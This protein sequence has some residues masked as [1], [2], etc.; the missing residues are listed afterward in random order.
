MAHPA[1][2]FPGL[3]GGVL[4]GHPEYG[5]GAQNG[6]LECP[7]LTMSDYF[8]LATVASTLRP[9]ADDTNWNADTVDRGQAKAETR[10]CRTG[11]E[12]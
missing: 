1:E 10:L 2:S 8:R 3:L 9:I 5:I 4:A 11:V 6:A 7:I 12:W